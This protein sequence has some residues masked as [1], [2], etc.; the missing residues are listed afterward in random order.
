MYLARGGIKNEIAWRFHDFFC[1][2]GW[3]IG[4]VDDP[5]HVFL[6][7]DFRPEVTWLPPPGR[8]R[9]VADPFGIADDEGVYV[10]CEEFDYRS[11]K[12]VIS[13]V[14]V[15]RDGVP[16]ARKV[17]IELSFHMSYPYIFEWKGDV[18]CLPETHQAREISLYRAGHFPDDWTKVKTLVPNFAGVDPTVFFHQG[19]WWMACGDEDTGPNDALFV[20]HAQEPFGPWEPHLKNPVRMGRNGTRPAGTPFEYRGD[21]YRPAMD[22]SRIYGRRIVLNRVKRLTPTEFEEEPAGIIE[23]FARGSY[24]DGVHT[25]SALGDLTLVDGLRIMFER[26][27]FKRAVDRERREL[28]GW[29]SNLWHKD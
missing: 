29:S 15:S 8:G 11:Y 12:G 27:E 28:F 9:F 1:H 24:R 20:W 22:S 14:R 25:V 10:F 19:R 7:P 4:I 23:P 17:A 26:T 6:E 5:I 18:Y 21:L 13:W 3:N 16:S 2:P